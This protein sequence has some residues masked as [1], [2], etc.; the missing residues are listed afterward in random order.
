LLRLRRLASVVVFLHTHDAAPPAT[1][2]HAAFQLYAITVVLGS[3]Y[4]IYVVAPRIGVA[5]ARPLLPPAACRLP[6]SACRHRHTACPLGKRNIFVYITICSVIGSLSVIGV[7][8]GAAAWPGCASNMPRPGSMW[9]DAHGRAWA[10][11]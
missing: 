1:R 2:L 8:V 11:P 9:L 5:K 10:S 3:L 7:K 6:P 4:L